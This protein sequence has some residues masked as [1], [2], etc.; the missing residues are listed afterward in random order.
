[1]ASETRRDLAVLVAAGI[2]FVCACLVLSVPGGPFVSPDETANAFFAGTFAEHGRLYAFEPLNEILGDVLH[3]RSILSLHGRLVPASFPG[4]PVLYGLAA[5]LLGIGALPLLTPVVAFLAVLAWYGIVRKLF[6]PRVAR[7]A[8]LLLF[9]HPAWWYYAARSL[10]HNVLFTSLLIGSVFF[11]LVQPFK[12][13]RTRG[14]RF[15]PAAA[16][17]ALV[18]ICFGL[19]VFVRASEAF[20]M[21]AGG[22]LILVWLHRHVA[23]QAVAWAVL[24]AVLAVSPLFFFNQ[25]LYGSPVS[26]GYTLV[27]E[28]TDEASQAAVSAP[29]GGSRSVRSLVAPFGIHPRIAWSHLLAYGITLFWWMAVLAVPGFFLAF[30]KRSDKGARR[31]WRWL[32]LAVFL[33]VGGWLALL[34]GSWTI[35][36]NPDPAAV[37]IGNSYVRYWLP[38]FVLTTPFAALAILWVRDLLLHPLAQ[39]AWAV[40]A[41]LAVFGLGVHGAFF[42]SAD[43]LVLA[44]RTLEAAAKT[45]DQVLGLTEPDAVIV[46]DRADKLFFPHR[47]VRYPLRDEATYA[48]LPRIA[49]RAP[50]YYFGITLPETDLAYLN[51]DKLKGLGLGIELVGTYGEESLYRMTSLG[52]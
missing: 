39:R 11:A 7:W 43:S 12:G 41:F 6:D 2:L 13:L 45:R 4:L 34:Y 9:A 47:R 49:L 36:D 27:A 40:G 15:I 48:L 5:R 17:P 8:A 50:L 37:T 51:D 22:L 29:L 31:Q 33:F 44:R 19:A 18:G 25:A 30:P 35:H 38:A 26:T 16:D 46:V 14:M 1:M 21:L 3:P 32:Y 24:G 52:Q 42:A 10:M 23:R 20:W 28:T